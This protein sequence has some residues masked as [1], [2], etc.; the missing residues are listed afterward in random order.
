MLEVVIALQE[1]I[2]EFTFNL[3]DLRL[4][5]LFIIKMKCH[6]M[7]GS[8]LNIIYDTSISKLCYVNHDTQYLY[9]HSIQIYTIHY[10]CF[11][12]IP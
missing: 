6:V 4:P 11:I 9:I 12:K 5:V 8:I 7:V 10:I 2:I 1:N 3:L